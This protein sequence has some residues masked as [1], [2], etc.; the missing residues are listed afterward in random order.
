MDFIGFIGFQ[1]RSIYWLRTEPNYI[2]WVENRNLFYFL[3]QEK[4]YIIF[5]RS[6]TGVYYVSWIENKSASYVFGSE[7][8]CILFLDSRT[9]T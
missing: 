4:E 2:L 9:E 3:G 8:K 1:T 6:G 7:Q 5:L